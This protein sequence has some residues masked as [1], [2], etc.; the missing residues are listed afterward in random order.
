MAKILGNF[1]LALLIGIALLVAVMV[2]LHR[3]R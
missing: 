2:G 1:H 3:G